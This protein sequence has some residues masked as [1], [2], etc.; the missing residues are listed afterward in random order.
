[1]ESQLW[2]V[3]TGMGRG[4]T[5]PLISYWKRLQANIRGKPDIMKVVGFYLLKLNLAGQRA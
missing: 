1:M 5:M 3:E 2:L 4:R